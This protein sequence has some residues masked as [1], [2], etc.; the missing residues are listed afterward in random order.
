MRIQLKIRSLEKAGRLA[1]TVSVSAMQRYRGRFFGVRLVGLSVATS[2]ASFHSSLLMR[3]DRAMSSWRHPG[4]SRSMRFRWGDKALWS[5]G[6]SVTRSIH[7]KGIGMS[8][9]S[10][11]LGVVAYRSLN[12]LSGSNGY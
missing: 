11:F 2:P 8:S 4:M 9:V 12:S 5:Q 1:I 10:S 6:L 7:D 3:V